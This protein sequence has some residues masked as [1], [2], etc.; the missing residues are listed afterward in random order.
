VL[1]ATVQGNPGTIDSK[2]QAG[3]MPPTTVQGNPG[4]IDS[5][6]QAGLMPPAT[7][8]GNPG[9]SDSKPLTLPATLVG[10]SG[11]DKQ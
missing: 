11:A 5:K 3:L 6:P 8:Q 7:V 4:T 2:P 1:P 9:S 10:T